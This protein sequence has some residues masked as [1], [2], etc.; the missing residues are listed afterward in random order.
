VGGLGRGRGRGRRL[1]S[2]HEAGCDF[3]VG[4]GEDGEYRDEDEEV[5][6]GWGGG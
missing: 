1:T 5:D 4:D 3:Q 2:W 6:L